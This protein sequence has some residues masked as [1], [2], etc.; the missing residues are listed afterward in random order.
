MNARI[1]ELDTAPDLYR[2]THFWTHGVKQILQDI[3]KYGFSEF[4][5]WPTARFWFYPKFAYGFWARCAETAL[6][7]VAPHREQ[8]LFRKLPEKT[9]G[10]LS[11]IR[12][13]DVL[14]ALWNHDVWPTDFSFG[15]NPCGHPGYLPSFTGPGGARFNRA[16][17]NYMLCLSMLSRHLTERPRRFLELGGGFGALGE[18]LYGLNRES[19]YWNYDLP[20]L[21]VVAEYYLDTAF[22]DDEHHVRST[23]ELPSHADPVDVFVNTY[24]FQEMEPHVVKN[25][26]EVVNKISPEFIL[27]LNSTN[28]KRRAK[29]AQGIGVVEPVTSSFI[30]RQFAV[31]GY[32][33]CGNYKDPYQ[34]GAGTLLIM[35]RP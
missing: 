4:K 35:R 9:T 1:A 12:D 5:R 15:E 27:S 20:P 32:E 18:I 13:F 14:R 26:V 34:R 33:V 11:G 30:E 31:H 2:P 24:S 10:R 29:S 25:Y 21:S 22:P 23:W 28:G 8:K 6:T 3:D 19:M 16:M 17:M 7:H